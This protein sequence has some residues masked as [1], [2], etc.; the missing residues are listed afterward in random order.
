MLRTGLSSFIVGLGVFA[1]HTDQGA[2]TK[3]TGFKTGRGSFKEFSARAGTKTAIGT[4]SFA[5][6]TER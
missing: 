3:V 6:E 5:K 4:D 2:S 1:P